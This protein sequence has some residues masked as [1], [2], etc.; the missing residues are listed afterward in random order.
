MKTKVTKTGKIQLVFESMAEVNSVAAIF[1]SLNIQK[2]FEL[3]ETFNSFGLKAVCNVEEVNRLYFE[4]QANV[5]GK[6][7]NIERMKKATRVK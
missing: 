3:P 5:L 6:A 4:Y 7:F 1:R 2:Q